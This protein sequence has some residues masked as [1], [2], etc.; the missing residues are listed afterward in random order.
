MTATSTLERYKEFWRSE[1][2]HLSDPKRLPK[3]VEDWKAVTDAFDAETV[4]FTAGI[5]TRA[6]WHHR[7]SRRCW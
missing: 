3:V 5:G 6:K 1:L 4:L 7:I 2:G